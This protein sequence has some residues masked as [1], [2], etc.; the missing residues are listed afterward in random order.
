[1][2]WRMS[3][4]GEKPT[5]VVMHVKRWIVVPAHA[6]VCCALGNRDHNRDRARDDVTRMMMRMHRTIWAL[7]PRRT[8]HNLLLLV[9]PVRPCDSLS[10]RQSS[11]HNSCWDASCNLKMCVCVCVWVV[12]WV[13]PYLRVAAN[14]KMT[15]IN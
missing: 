2:A 15:H 14:R 1:M 11:P 10:T 6:V 12:G 13:E 8:M 5:A 3:S 4:H 7:L 9:R